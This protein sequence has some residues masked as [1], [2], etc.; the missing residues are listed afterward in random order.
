MEKHNINEP[1]QS[2]Y[3]AR[4]STETALIRIQ[5]DSDLDIKRGVVLVLLDLSATFDTLDHKVLKASNW[6]TRWNPQVVRKLS[7]WSHARSECRQRSSELIVFEFGAPHAPSSRQTC[8]NSI[9]SLLATSS[10]DVTF[11][12]NFMMTMDNYMSHLFWTMMMTLVLHLHEN[13]DLYALQQALDDRELFSNSTTTK[14]RF[15]S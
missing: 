13:R 7:L 14:L 5:N 6:T 10:D 9:Q 3:G 1:L 2:V 15:W 11:D 12:S 4:H 8:I